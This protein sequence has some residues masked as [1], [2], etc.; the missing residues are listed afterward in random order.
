MLTALEKTR[1]DK[2]RCSAAKESEQQLCQPTALLW[3]EVWMF[4][5][6][7]KLPQRLACC[8]Q[9]GSKFRCQDCLATHARTSSTRHWRG[10]LRKLWCPTSRATS[11]SITWSA[12]A[13]TATKFR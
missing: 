5:S 7:Q 10:E 9:N 2:S 3:D 4:Q 8:I 13:W 1:R 6:R 12:S 11:S